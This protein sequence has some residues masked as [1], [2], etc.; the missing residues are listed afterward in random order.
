MCCSLSVSAEIAGDCDSQ[1]NRKKTQTK[2][3]HKLSIKLFEKFVFENVV[4]TD[5]FTQKSTRQLWVTIK[6]SV[7]FAHNA[8]E[9]A[10][11]FD[12]GGGKGQIFAIA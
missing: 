4:G 10:A 8:D 6:I 3:T 7:K 2:F 11:I 9:V 12:V 1:A 5:D